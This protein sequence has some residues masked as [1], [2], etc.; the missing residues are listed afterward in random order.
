MDFEVVLSFLATSILLS[1]AP[2]PDILYVLALSIS[3]GARSALT[4]SLGL[5]SGIV[6]HT[7]ICAAGLS[8]LIVN[9]PKAFWCVKI[10]GAL[11]LAYLACLALREDPKQNAKSANAQNSEKKSLKNLYARGIMMNLLNPKVLLFFIAFLPQFTRSDST[12]PIWIQIIIL[13]A[14]FFVSALLVMGSVAILGAKL[15]P[16]LARG[17]FWIIEKYVRVA[18]FV[19]LAAAS[20]LC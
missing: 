13:G 8:I 10:F 16:I 17:A 11:Y 6:A 9:S 19:S 15:K 14:I 7:A 12:F 20:L 4:L 3:K 2:G 18:I 1:A 5:V